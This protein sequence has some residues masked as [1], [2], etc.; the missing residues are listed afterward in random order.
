MW[1]A[2]IITC[3]TLFIMVHPCN[4]KVIRDCG[5]SNSTITSHSLFV[6]TFLPH[7]TVLNQHVWNNNSITNE[8]CINFI[9]L[10]HTIINNDINNP[11]SQ[12]YAETI[13][14]P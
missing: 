8:V 9:T 5:S 14:P 11:D 7:P 6:S 2:F 4:V 10:T 3:K 1:L 12:N 13:H